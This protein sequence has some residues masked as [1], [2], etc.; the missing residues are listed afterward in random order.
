[1]PGTI[2][3]GDEEDYTVV[4]IDVDPDPVGVASQKALTNF[5]GGRVREIEAVDLDGDGK[6]DAVVLTNDFSKS[7]A[8]IGAGLEDGPGAAVVLDPL[9]LAADAFVRTGF[10]ADFG[11]VADVDGDGHAD[12]IVA[13]AVGRSNAE[14]YVL[15]GDG[16]GGLEPGDRSFQLLS[17]RNA[18]KIGTAAVAAADMNGDGLADV[19]MVENGL[20]PP[21]LVL[22]NNT[23]R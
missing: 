4:V 5:Q 23:S 6:D 20:E 12:V 22:W 16:K 2:A 7:D 18:L 9:G 1:V 15:F 11:A 17:G 8:L 14:W 10:P 3:I 19:F 13:R 21:N